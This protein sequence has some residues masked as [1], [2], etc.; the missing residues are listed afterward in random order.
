MVSGYMRDV[1]W[2]TLNHKIDLDKHASKQAS[3]KTDFTVDPTDWGLLRLAVGN[4]IRSYNRKTNSYREHAS[5]QFI[6]HNYMI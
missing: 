1:V 6:E 5:C 3:E 2:F 4:K